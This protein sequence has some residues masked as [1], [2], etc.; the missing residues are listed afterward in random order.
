MPRTHKALQRLFVEAPLR[1]GDE[2]TLGREQTN[3]LV[4]VLRRQPGDAVILFN[5]RDGAW[6]AEIADASR[7][8]VRLALVEQT[9]PQTPSS[10]LWF[11]FAPLKVGRLDYVV[12]KAT[13]LGAGSIQPVLTQFTQVSRLRSDK[14]RANIIEAAEQCEVLTVPRLAP[15][16]KLGPLLEGWQETHGERRLVVCD[17]S[18]PPS[19]PVLPLQRLAGLPVGVLVGPEGGFSDEE[20]RL[21]LAQPFV[22]PVSLGPRILRADTA[23]VAVLALVQAIIGDWR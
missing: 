16:Q 10:D 12:Q 8:A 6:K 11:G 13:E 7:K 2:L 20:R 5:G 3:Y 4:A 23:A 17:E 15:E 14:L 1:M 21:L 19:S 9:A 22:V 18:A